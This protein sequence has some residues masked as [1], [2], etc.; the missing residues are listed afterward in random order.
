ME[1]GRDGERERERDRESIS[2][3]HF[4]FLDLVMLIQRFFCGVDK[5]AVT[6]RMRRYGISHIAFVFR[7]IV[8]PCA[9]TTTDTSA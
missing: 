5:H 7:L 8:R 1:E 3:C 2:I 6:F 9:R 4:S